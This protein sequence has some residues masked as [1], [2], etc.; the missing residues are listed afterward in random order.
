[1]PG[2]PGSYVNGTTE[3]SLHKEDS[4]DG[5]FQRHEFCCG[6][7][8]LSRSVSPT[9]MTSKLLWNKQNIKRD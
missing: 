1:M 7:F 4:E 5:L 9:E 8:V 2:H 6:T 3:L